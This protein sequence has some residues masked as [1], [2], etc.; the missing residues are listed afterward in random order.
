MEK[1]TRNNRVVAITKILLENPNKILGLNKFSELLNAAKS[2]IS[3][4]IVVVREILERLEM[5][6]VET[7]CRSSRWD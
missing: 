1:F 2:T 7:I 5:G 6:K 4:D 3:E